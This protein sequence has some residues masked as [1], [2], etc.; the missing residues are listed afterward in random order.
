MRKRLFGWM[1]SLVKPM[2]PVQL[3]Q[4]L[5]RLFRTELRVWFEE[6]LPLRGCLL[7]AGNHRSMLDVPLLIQ[8]LQQP[9]HPICHYYLSQVPVIKDLIQQLGGIHLGQ[10]GKG[11]SQLFAQASQVLQQGEHVVIFPEGGQRMTQRSPSGQLAPFNRGFAHLAYRSGLTELPVVPVAI[12][13]RQEMSGP[14]VPLALLGWFDPLEP[15]FQGADWHPYVYYR[16]VYI[17]VG[18]PRFL[19][20]EET[21]R[22]RHGQS[23]PVTAQLQADLEAQTQALVQRSYGLSW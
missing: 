5:V 10:G 18:R 7:V 19:T 14:L 3:A 17:M 15:L 21:S 8:A 13:S 20:A 23:R 1:I 12:V 6:P 9:V 16:R 11:W 22:Y 4:T 2:P